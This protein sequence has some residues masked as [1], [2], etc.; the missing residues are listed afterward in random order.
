[1][2]ERQIEALVV[3]VDVARLAGD[4]ARILE[5]E[6]EIREM[7]GGKPRKITG[8]CHIGGKPPAMKAQGKVEDFDSWNRRS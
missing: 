1:M 4:T 7:T 2:S 6:A 3:Q 5:I 8:V